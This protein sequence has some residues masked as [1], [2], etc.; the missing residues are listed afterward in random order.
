[1]NAIW[2]LAKKDLLLLT[3]D[4][5]SLFWMVLFPFVFAV[6][7]GSIF[8]GTG[9]GNSK[10][11]VVVAVSEGLDPAKEAFLERL[12]QRPVEIRRAPR[13]EAREQVRKGRAGAYLDLIKIPADPFAT[14]SGERAEIEIGV[15]PSR[16]AERAMLEG[17]VVE[18]SFGG[19]REVFTDREAG[20][21][22]ARRAREDA[23]KATD[24]PAGQ[25][26]VLTA[27]LGALETFFGQVDLT[28]GGGA[29]ANPMSGPRIRTV[30]VTRQRDGPT[31]AYEISFPQAILWGLLG[32]A[33]AFAQTFVRERNQGTLVR[34]W[35]APIA[36]TAV[37]GG[38]LLACAIAAVGVVT[39]L[40]LAG[41]VVFGV[42]V[43]EPATLIAAIAGSAVCFGGLSVLLSTIGRTEQA[44]A[45]IAWGVLC[46]L[47][48]IGGGMVPQ[49][50]MPPW[51]MT[52]G[53][54]SPAR[55]AIQALEGGIWRG[56]S[57]AEVAPAVG[58]LC[59]MGAVGLGL[60]VFRLRRV[61]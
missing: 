8:G 52:V 20:Q 27:F 19:L 41:A 35:A 4:R 3:R 12:S 6:F 17:F 58:V 33:A 1:M 45:G 59:L 2:T 24:M 13:E 30:D 21:K 39:I 50:I 34:L 7:F 5:V 29:D 26:L 15:D 23:A 37:L 61:G 54:V 53:A 44:N 46:L 56:T 47:A 14:F 42:G 43:A 40:L 16:L 25:R 51:M 31:N 28:Q 9:N 60:G 57:L 22:A 11:I 32:C 38:K 48:M 55:W 10:K 36:R 49:I 18:A